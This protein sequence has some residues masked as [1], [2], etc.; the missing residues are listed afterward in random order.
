MKVDGK[1]YVLNDRT[2]W[3][4]YDRKGEFELC[5]DQVWLELEQKGLVKHKKFHS[6]LNL[7]QYKFSPEMPLTKAQI[8]TLTSIIHTI[9]SR[10][11]QPHKAGF[12]P[13][14]M[15]ISGD[16]GT[17]KTVVA[18]ALF[19]YLRTHEEY[20]DLK[21][22]LVYAESSTREEIQEVFKSVKGVRKKDVISPC[23]VTKEPY[24]IIICDEAHRLRRPQNA[25]RYYTA[26]MKKINRELGIDESCDELDWI[27]S[28]S[29]YQILFYDEKQSVS[30]SDIPTESFMERLYERKRGIRPIELKEQ[31]RIAAGDSY[32]PYIYDI[33]YHRVPVRK[34]FEGYEFVLF[35]SFDKMFERLREKEKTVGLSRMCG[36]Y[37]W[38]WKAKNQSNDPDI[39]LGDMDIWWNKQTK[40]WLRNPEATE[41]MGSIYTLPGL[42]LN[43]AAVVIGPELS[44]DPIN[45]CIKIDPSHYYDNKVK[46]NT[47]D[48][49]LKRYI[50]NTY[51]VFMT[52]GIKGTCIYVCD[53]ALRAYLQKYIPVE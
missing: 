12:L 1:F 53:D 14:P 16:P 7:S 45:D 49:D 24:D 51:A 23:A 30:P 50:L 33:L 15:L 11:T 48:D 46:T 34:M 2:E 9:D 8:D 31:M 42:D 29:K 3:Q 4:H 35:Q 44:Y 43:Y 5:F 25:G 41:E 26:K 38:E 27:L 39:K 20:R 18:T 37:A 19:Y 36:G 6:V 52:R 32:V 40:G 21:I 22:G 13:R 28:C 10:E 47:S 17:G